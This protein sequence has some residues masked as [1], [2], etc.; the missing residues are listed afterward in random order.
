MGDWRGYDHVGESDHVWQLGGEYGN[1]VSCGDTDSPQSRSYFLLAGLN[2]LWIP[3]VYLCMLSML[4]HRA[5]TNESDSLSRDSQSIPRVN[6]RP[7]LHGQ[8]FPL[9]NG[10]SIQS[11]R[12]CSGGAR[13]HKPNL[14]S[15]QDRVE[16][17]P[18][19][20]ST[21]D[22]LKMDQLTTAYAMYIKLPR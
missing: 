10:A 15:W 5:A 14:P 21:C 12:R 20:G 7:F 18:I 4:D 19:G 2:L 13:C 22:R 16:L 17:R 11:P 3:I 8:S 6:R 9:E 1:V